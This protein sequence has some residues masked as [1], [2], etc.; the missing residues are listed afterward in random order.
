MRYAIW[1][2]IKIWGTYAKVDVG[3]FRSIP[4]RIPDAWS[5][6]TAVVLDIFSSGAGRFLEMTCRVTAADL[7]SWE[8]PLCPTLTLSARIGRLTHPASCPDD[9]YTRHRQQRWSKQKH[10]HNFWEFSRVFLISRAFHTFKPS[11]PSIGPWGRCRDAG[12]FRFFGGR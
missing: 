11:K 7:T 9:T 1:H 5:L 6:V 8:W 2:F 10:M 3:C 4:I 12:V